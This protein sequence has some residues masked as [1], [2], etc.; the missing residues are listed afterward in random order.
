VEINLH[1]LVDYGKD[2]IH[3]GLPV[4]DRYGDTIGTLYLSIIAVDAL[5]HVLAHGQEYSM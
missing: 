2:V 3:E 4:K 5:K 1:S